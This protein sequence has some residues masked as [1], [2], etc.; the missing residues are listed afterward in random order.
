[1]E[2]LTKEPPVK[3]KEQE[4]VEAKQAEIDGFKMPE[5]SDGEPVLFFEHGIKVRQSIAFVQK[6]N[7]KGLQLRLANSLVHSNVPHVDD[8]RLKYN[9]EMRGDGAWEQTSWKKELDK[10]LDLMDKR[11][12]EVESLVNEPLKKN[13]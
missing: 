8:P 13:K 9:P 3:T 2:T 12:K 5:T 11:L 10:K 4:Q 6:R 1:M 7:A